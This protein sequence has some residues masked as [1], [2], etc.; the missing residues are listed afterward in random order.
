MQLC[1]DATRFNC[2]LDG[3]IEL[4]AQKRLAAV[5]YSFAPFA[6]SGKNA[7]TLDA[8]EVDNLERVARQA[9]NAG[10]ELACLNLDYCLNA[11]DKKSARQFN[12]ML[13]KVLRVATIVG[14]KRVSF[15]VIPGNEENWVRKLTDQL[16]QVR[17]KAGDD[18][19]R[20]L[21]RLSTA[22]VFRNQSLKRWRAMEPQDWRDLIS[23]SLNLGLNFSPADCVWL[24]IDYLRILSGLITAIE[25]VEAHDIE[26]SREL[27]AD[28]G[29]YGPLWWRYRMPGKG[30]VDWRQF[31][32]ALKLYDFGGTISIHM[33]DEFVHDD[34]EDLDNALKTSINFLAPLLRG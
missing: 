19:V 20:L 2:G 30:Q 14:C 21:L 8:K 33:D 17:D 28:S 6:A 29:I 27:L 10:V 16:D 34:P 5:E 9:E 26:I 22:K 25:H 1:F 13:T 12:T 31:I 23:H 32:E 18:S 3:A 15:S 24:G 7:D 4:A 11:E